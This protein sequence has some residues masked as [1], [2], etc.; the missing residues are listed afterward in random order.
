[1]KVRYL[2]AYLITLTLL[3]S[4]CSILSN[5][6]VKVITPSNNIIGETR[7]VSGFT[8]VDFSTFGKVNM[9]QSNTETLSINGPD[10][11]VS[12][13]S[14]TVSNGTLVIKN[15]ENF[16]V[17]SLSSKDILTFTIGFKTLTSLNISGAGDV[18]VETFNTPSMNLAM[19][20]AGN[21]VMNQ[22]TT[23]SLNVNLSGLGGLEI[24]GSA[25]QATIDI[26]GAGSVNAP[27]MKLS[28]ANVTISGLGGATLWVTDSLTGE[29]SGAGSISYYGSPQTSTQASGL[30]QFKSLGSK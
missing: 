23:N 11:L 25:A 24:T 8:G 27:D 9:I 20:G 26:S 14:T 3:L 10:N 28:K 2:L 22:L 1:M 6:G 21:V 13:I 16:T 15:K 5:F 18:Q 29:I 19:S 4:S 30:G 7:Q 12:E 17:S